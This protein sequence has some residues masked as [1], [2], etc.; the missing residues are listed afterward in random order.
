MTSQLNVDTIVDKAGSGGVSLTQSPSLTTPSLSGISNT[1]TATGEGG[2]GTAI[3]VQGL[4]KVWAST[5][6][7]GASITDSFNVA[8]LTDVGT[9]KQQPNFT[10]NMNNATFVINVTFH[11][12][13]I[14]VAPW[15]DTGTTSS[16]KTYCYTGSAYY[17]AMMFSAVQGD[18]A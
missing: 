5:P 17:D 14:G 15:A 18:L 2:S 11:N 9:G 3:V 1:S 6:A 8:S 12:N 7:D 10:N 16:Y 13:A 4:S